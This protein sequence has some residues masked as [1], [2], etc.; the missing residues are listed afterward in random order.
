MMGKMSEIAML[1][2]D[3]D[4]KGLVEFFGKQGWKKSVAEIGGK[5]FLKAFDE[6]KADKK[7]LFD[8]LEE[9]DSI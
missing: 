6:I 2:Q 7:L 4:E 8:N 9:S 1:L 5:E 3:K